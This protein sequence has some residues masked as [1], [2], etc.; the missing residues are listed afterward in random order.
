M[1]VRR[2]RAS[3]SSSEGIPPLVI[4]RLADQS[5]FPKDSSVDRDETAS[6][7]RGN[8]RDLDSQGTEQTEPRQSTLRDMLLFVSLRADRIL[9]SKSLRA[10]VDR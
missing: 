10:T 5:I 8:N 6:E 2:S 7:V 1:S 4:E 3:S 9:F